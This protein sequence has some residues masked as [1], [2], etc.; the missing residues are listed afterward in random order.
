MIKKLPLASFL[1][2]FARFFTRNNFLT[3][4]WDFIVPHKDRLI[5]SGRTD[6][7]GKLC[8]NYFVSN[9]LTQMVD[10][11]NESLTVTLTFYSCGSLL[12]NSDHAVVWVSINFP[13]KSKGEAAFHC[14]AYDYSCADWGGLHNHLRDVP[15]KDIFKLGDTT[16]G[17]E[18][19]E[20]DPAETIVTRNFLVTMLKL[21]YI[22]LIVS[23]I[24]LHGFEL[25]VRLP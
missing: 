19:C 6:R 16:A 22:S 10:Y 1:G 4:I 2:R 8:Y 15:W 25:L 24:Q 23:L 17:I 21:M 3:L 7:P 5:Y 13:S 12:G 11:P 9:D 14:K 20:F 18:Y